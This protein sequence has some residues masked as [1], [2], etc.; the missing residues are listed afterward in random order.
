MEESVREDNSHLL[1]PGG[2]MTGLEVIKG[3]ISAQSHQL[4]NR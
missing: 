1:S 3:K 4:F 2:I